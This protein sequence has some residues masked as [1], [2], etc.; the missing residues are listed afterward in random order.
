VCNNRSTTDIIESFLDDHPASGYAELRE[1]LFSLLW[2]DCEIL[3]RLEGKGIDSRNLLKVVHQ[4]QLL[5]RE[6]KSQLYKDLISTSLK[7]LKAPDEH[8]E[9]SRH[10]SL[11]YSDTLA[12]MVA[13]DLAPASAAVKTITILLKNPKTGR[14][15]FNL[16]NRTVDICADKLDSVNMAEL[17]GVLDVCGGGLPWQNRSRELAKELIAKAT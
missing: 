1:L 16:L 5:E 17:Q 2:D 12:V 6:D 10:L 11:A 8:T 9:R 3:E 13:L 15:G 4:I 7:G 14:S